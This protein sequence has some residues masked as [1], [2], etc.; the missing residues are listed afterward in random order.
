MRT[1]L[2]VDEEIR[3]L[4][5]LNF[6]FTLFRVSSRFSSNIRWANSKVKQANFVLVS[7]RNKCSTFAIHSFFFAVVGLILRQSFRERC[8]STHIHTHSHTERTDIRNL[9]H[10]QDAIWWIKCQNP[11]IL[12]MFRFRIHRGRHP[13]RRPSI[14]VCQSRLNLFL[15][16]VHSIDVWI[17]HEW[18][19]QL[20]LWVVIKLELL[21]VRES[22]N[23]NA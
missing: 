1:V 9:F 3:L 10:G 4:Y 15:Y 17:Y 22:L 14:S 11:I 7:I 23:M 8:T 20:T 16:D 6:A 19:C 18:I 12:D 13:K 2:W 5:V 21:L